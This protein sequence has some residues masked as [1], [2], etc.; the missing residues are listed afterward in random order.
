MSH[1]V[2][3][4]SLGV[5]VGRLTRGKMRYVAGYGDRLLRGGKASFIAD[6]TNIPIRTRW[7]CPGMIRRRQH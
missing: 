7:L 3:G 4:C 1:V 6:G 5:R 2:Y